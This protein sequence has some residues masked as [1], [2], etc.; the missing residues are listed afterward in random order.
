[1]TFKGDRNQKMKF[2]FLIGVLLINLIIGNYLLVEVEGCSGGYKPSNPSAKQCIDGWI[3][4][5]SDCNRCYC[6]KNRNC[7]KVLKCTEIGCP[8]EQRNAGEVC[9]L[10]LNNCVDG[11]KCQKVTDICEF[12]HDVLYGRCLKL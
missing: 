4:S 10:S 12:L 6:I 11:F 8:T 3:K 7:S 1:M 9:N 2:S 5:P